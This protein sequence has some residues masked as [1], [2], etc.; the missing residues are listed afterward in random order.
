MK[1]TVFMGASVDGFIARPDGALD[2]LPADG[3][4]QHGFEDLMAEVDT[5][6]M[7]RKTFE[8][9]LGFAAWPYAG[10]RVVVLSNGRHGRQDVR[11]N[12]IE[13]M[14]GD[15]KAIATRLEATGSRSVYAD[16]GITVQGFL[17][18]GLVQRLVVTRVPILIGQGIPLFGSLPRDI[19]LRH[20]G[21]QSYPSGLVKS[22]YVV[23]GAG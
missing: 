2:F 17:R 13:W 10:K 21:T 3:G 22:E 18:A 9:V 6:V 1:V 19:R 8:S 16:G 11:G 7:G 23:I 20:I 12:E 15:A 5:V 4:E 14:G